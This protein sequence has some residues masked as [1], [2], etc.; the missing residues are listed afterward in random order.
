MSAVAAGVRGSTARSVMERLRD[1][2]DVSD[3][4]DGLKVLLSDA[5]DRWILV[6][7][8]GTEPALRVYAEAPTQGEADGIVA[9]YAKMLLGMDGVS[10]Y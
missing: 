4:S 6:R 3:D 10:P 2:L 7:P 8:S 9:E 5:G 1:E